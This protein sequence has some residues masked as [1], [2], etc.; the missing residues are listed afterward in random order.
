MHTTHTETATCDTNRVMLLS[1]LSC[2]NNVT[3]AIL[4]SAARVLR[5]DPRETVFTDSLSW[6]EGRAHKGH[7]T[8][9]KLTVPGG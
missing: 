3:V 8:C 9:K 6:K 1:L 2:G 4:E 7:M 5:R